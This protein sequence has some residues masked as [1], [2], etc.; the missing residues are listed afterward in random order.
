MAVVSFLGLG[1]MGFP[2][3]GHL[4]AAGHDVVV[5]N[6]TSAVAQQWV[7]QH[8]GRM[9]AT[10]AEAALDADFV[11]SCVGNDND[12]R[13]VLCGPEGALMGMR[14]GSILVDHTTASAAL[15][16]EVFQ[17]AVER[18]V[19]FLDAPAGIME[20]RPGIAAQLASSR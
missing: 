6:R 11:F 14:R 3:A 16:R 13:E 18:G 1:V 2:M 20:E 10:P 5:Y 12:V 8:G 17:A 19:G 9:A 4:A 7:D 15:A